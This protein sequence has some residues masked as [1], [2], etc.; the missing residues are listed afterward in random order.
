MNRQI[1]ETAEC[2]Y[3][4]AT[5]KKNILLVSD[6][7]HRMSTIP[8]DADTVTQLL[9]TDAI[10]NAITANIKVIV[11]PNKLTLSDVP[12]LLKMITNIA[13]VVNDVARNDPL[14]NFKDPEGVVNIIEILITVV[15]QMAL[16]PAD[17]DIIKTFCLPA[18]ELL[19]T[20]IAISLQGKTWKQMFVCDKKTK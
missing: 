18:F 3:R 4:Q 5:G 12:A 9:S 1:F 16:P 10:V 13:K 14:I 6:I 11:F 8:I 17:Y 20:N 15:L 19:K 2:I 7:D